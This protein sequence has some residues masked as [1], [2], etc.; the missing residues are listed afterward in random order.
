MPDVSPT[1][2]YVPTRAQDRDPIEAPVTSVTLLED[3]A[4][5]HRE[6]TLTLEPGLHR[7]VIEAVAPVIQDV[8]VRAHIP[9][10]HA[11]ATDISMRRALRI[12][13][14]HQPADVR[15]LE[16][17][18]REETHRWNHNCDATERAVTRLD[19]LGEMLELGVVETPEDA[20][21]GHADPEEWEATFGELFTRSR[22][23]R[24][25]LIELEHERRALERRLG[26][27]TRRRRQMD[28]PDTAFRGWL[29]VDVRIEQAAPCTLA[30]DYIT[31]NAMWR[32]MHTAR[33]V[34]GK[35]HFTSAAMVWQNTGED[36]RD[37]EVTFSTAR[38]SLGTEPPLL[39][40]DLLR[41]QR[42]TGET[43]VS[44]REVEVESA[45][46]SGASAGGA[47]KG[48][49]LP[50]VEDGGEIRTLTAPHR[51]DLPSD[52][53]P[54]RIELF[55]FEDEA[56]LAHILMPEATPRV[57]LRSTQRNT[58]AHP[59][60]AGPVELQRDGGTVGW[61][62]ALFIAPNEAFDLGFGPADELRVQRERHLIDEEVVRATQWVE[63]TYRV[64]VYLSNLSREARTLALTERVPVSELEEVE[65]R[66]DDAR[67]REGYTLNEDGFVEWEIEVAPASREVVQL[68]WT[69]AH[70]PGVEGI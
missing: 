10:D 3:R 5:V 68:V 14:T 47:D 61:S 29:E 56:T 30:I 70:A 13:R 45:S 44:V 36:W 51:C 57:I 55:A 6:T 54:N 46:A 16:D 1:T 39:R 64:R 53:A 42:T 49:E 33:L 25:Q 63:R 23:V 28:R 52:G 32:P 15:A 65:V 19:T 12:Q 8:S 2:T 24:A 62:Q 38:S 50:G 35:L 22:E 58:G 20:A 34:E 43:K 67:S 41:A 17:E 37:V 40:D 59:V 60:L 18:I 4:Q 7:L 9:E 27:A 69:L 66:I 31:P 26:N 21:W 11:H 48:V